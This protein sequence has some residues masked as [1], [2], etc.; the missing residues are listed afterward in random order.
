V[1]DVPAAKVLALQGRQ[2]PANKA[3][4]TD[5]QVAG[6]P[7]LKAFRQQVD[8]AV[9]MPNLPEMSMVWSPATTAMNTIVKKTATPKEAMDRAQKEVVQRIND[10]LKK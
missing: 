7:I 1:T 6:D 8:V 4:Y 2:T 9:P 5:P 3:V 10:L